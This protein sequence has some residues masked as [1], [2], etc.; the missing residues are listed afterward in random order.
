MAS[1]RSGADPQARLD[2][3]ERIRGLVVADSGISFEARAFEKLC[4]PIVYL[5]MKRGQPLYIGMSKRGLARPG[6]HL[7]HRAETISVSDEVMVWGCPT[8]QA[9]R[10]LESLLIGA[11]NP[12]LNRSGRRQFTAKLLG[13]R[14]PAP[15]FKAIDSRNMELARA[16]E[17]EYKGRGAPADMFI[18]SRDLLRQFAERDSAGLGV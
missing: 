3:T 12:L 17:A 18:G 10:E 14:R 7:H 13:R 9:A 8:E 6:S 2:L 16:A 1:T 5:F 4:G 11:L 15:N